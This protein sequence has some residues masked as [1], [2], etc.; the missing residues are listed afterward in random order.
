MRVI[1]YSDDGNN[2][3]SVRCGSRRWCDGNTVQLGEVMEALALAATHR[4]LPQRRKGWKR[5]ILGEYETLAEFQ[6]RRDLS[7]QI[8]PSNDMRTYK[9]E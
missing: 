1:V 8:N 4:D 7:R 9:T 3:F 5:W 6:L 2:V